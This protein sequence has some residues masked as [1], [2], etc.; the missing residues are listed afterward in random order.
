MAKAKK[1]LNKNF[2]MVVAS[3][4]AAI[5]VIG[6]GGGYMLYRSK[7]PDQLKVEGRDLMLKGEYTDA[8]NRFSRA[9]NRKTSDAEFLTW[10]QESETH[11]TSFDPVHYKASL[12]LLDAI[13]TASA[14]KVPPTL[15]KLEAFLT[16]IEANGIDQYPADVA[17]TLDSSAKMILERDP[18]NPSALRMRAYLKIMP[19]FAPGSVIS[20]PEAQTVVEDAKAILEISPDDPD[21]IIRYVQA[22]MKHR[23]ALL[24]EMAIPNNP[25]SEQARATYQELRG[26]SDRMLEVGNS[27][28][29]SAEQQARVHLRNFELLQIAW[30]YQLTPP[31][32]LGKV[33]VPRLAELI[34]RASALVTAE[35]EL[36]I[37]TRLTHAMF[38]TS[39]LFRNLGEAEKVLRETVEEAPKQ[40]RPRLE[41]ANVL[42]EAG[43]PKEAVEVLSVERSPDYDLTGISGLMFFYDRERVPLRR[44]YFRLKAIPL[45][46][47]DQRE[48]EIAKVETDYNAAVASSRVGEA[49]PY[50]LQVKA[51]LQELRN[52]RTGALATLN[53]AKSRLSDSP[54]GRPLLIKINEDCLRLERGMN[55]T[56]RAEQTALQLVRLA[57]TNVV[58]H[59]QYIDLL[60]ENGKQDDAWS[61]WE[62]AKRFWPD[63]PALAALEIRLLP[64]EASKL[65]RFEKLPEDT[66]E[67]A[68]IKMKF[69][70][71]EGFPNL[72]NEI[73]ERFLKD[74]PDDKAVTLMYCENLLKQGNRDEALRRLYALK[75]KDPSDLL[76]DRIIAA[77]KAETPEE[78]EKVL[79]ENISSASP[80]N[81]LLLE[82]KQLLDKGDAEG[83]IAKLREAEKLDTSGAGLVTERIYYHYMAQ[84]KLDEAEAEL[85]KLEKLK[86]DPAEIRT[87]RLRLALARAAVKQ[88]QGA[89]QEADRMF[90]EALNQANSLAVEMPNF[91]GAWVVKGLALSARGQ[92]AE[93]LDAFRA[94]LQAQPNNVEALQWAINLAYE[95]G[96][97]ADMKR[98]IDQAREQAKGNPYF[99]EQL[100]RYE[101]A[102]GDPTQAIETRI[103]QRDAQPQ[104]TRTWLALGD[105][106]QRSANKAT[107]QA[108]AAEYR[109][110]AIETY[111]QANEK[112]KDSPG[113]GLAAATV[114]VEAGNTDGAN[115]LIDSLKSDPTV[116]ANPGFLGALSK[117]YIDQRQPD[118]A[119]EALQKLL[120]T[121]KGNEG[122][123]RMQMAQL[124]ADAGRIDEAMAI[125]DR[126]P[127]SPESRQLRVN[128]LLS[129]RKLEDANRLTNSFLQKERNLTTLMMASHTE[130]VVGNIAR[131]VELAGEAVNLDP[132]NAT[133]RLVRAKAMMRERP[134]RNNVILEDLDA[135]KRLS[136]GNREA[137]VL[138]SER[139]SAMNRQDDAVAELESLA[140]DSPGNRDVL[141]LLI[142]GY[143]RQQ[144][145]PY[146]RIDAI[147]AELEK[148]GQMDTEM[149]TLAMDIAMKRGD[150]DRAILSGQAALSTDPGNATLYTKLVD[151]YVRKGAY[152]E[153]LA[154]LTKIQQKNES[155]YWTYMMRAVVLHRMKNEAE[156]AKEWDKALNVTMSLRNDAPTGEV[157]ERYAAEYGADA[158]GNW[159]ATKM[160]QDV[161]M[162]AL[163]L[164]IYANT[165]QYGKVL[166]MSEQVIPDLKA[167]NPEAQAMVM[168]NVGTAYLAKAPS[169]AGRA[170]QAFEELVKIQ[171]EDP[172]ALNNLAYA[173]ML[174]GA[175]LPAAARMAEKA[176]SLSRDSGLREAISASIADTYGWAL[177]QSGEVQ[178]G[179]DILRE[180]WSTHQLPDIAYHLGEAYVLERQKDAAMQSLQNALDLVK[181]MRENREA[182]DADLERRIQDAIVRA[183]AMEVQ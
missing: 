19:L 76:M 159:L 20:S 75:A 111:T 51:G 112:F 173:M 65:A 82:G 77:V 48:A 88:S 89:T 178:K 160:G 98:Y 21:L 11:L 127:D 167:L 136:P 94:A 18:K 116:M 120:D 183:N 5:G 123:I 24:R 14:D 148:N 170:R 41:L 103:K 107:D 162:R 152:R 115:K 63:Q 164:A 130:G 22:L 81:K 125:A 87:N 36:F 73:A 66:R 176:Y 26:F 44:A 53:Q 151:L 128:L 13:I 49:D 31:D 144:N 129:A 102:F 166:A 171:P 15:K 47:P 124:H 135:V 1:K 71:D 161:K 156:A 145:V 40:W 108:K 7:R 12:G 99:D 52:D 131:S 4:T 137:R 61:A 154:E 23:E 64:D 175:D 134:A 163:M 79:A 10:M 6:A 2:L 169:D 58:N 56:G 8:F 34:G 68:Q 182:V 119:V 165:G 117:Y 25:G 30:Q 50:A 179:I 91:S 9:G 42:A 93:S 38:L 84:G 105:A 83:Y 74:N 60:I 106:Y 113:F 45:L 157:V 92:N 17:R 139:L 43:K 27:A 28:S 62:D 138:M 57:P 33:V 143:A 100:L 32:E 55:Q 126:L 122:Q 168:R 146:A 16:D 118:L 172:E 109:Q 39:P 80:I 29:L 85:N 114:M 59:L 174:E 46:Q 147:F 101:V 3:V 110:K 155:F 104:D 96:R 121:G 140:E 37:K 86:R 90:E 97:G 78:L 142:N 141:K 54:E 35:N 181:K 180:A 177:I 67:K 95:L 133:A 149:H 132:N 150:I 153:V 70:S 158:T 69:A 72:V